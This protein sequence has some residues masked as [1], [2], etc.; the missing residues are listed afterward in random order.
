M[1][2]ASNETR[3]HPTA[4]S[5][6][7]DPVPPDHDSGH[8]ATKPTNA[9]LQQELDPIGAGG[10]PEPQNVRGAI[11]RGDDVA[12]AKQADDLDKISHPPTI[13]PRAS[14]PFADG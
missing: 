5:E 1:A 11:P 9:A 4:A 13:D 2:D 12:Q 6:G 10:R 3:T 8:T 7:T 14:P